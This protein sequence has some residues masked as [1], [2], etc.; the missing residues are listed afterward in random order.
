MHLWDA[1][2]QSAAVHGRWPQGRSVGTSCGKWDCGCELRL[3]SAALLDTKAWKG[4]P[5]GELSHA[6]C[7]CESCRDDKSGD[8]IMCSHHLGKCSRSEHISGCWRCTSRLFGWWA[9][10]HVCVG[11]CPV[12]SEPGHTVSLTLVKVERQ[13]LPL[14]SACLSLCTSESEHSFHVLATGRS[15]A[16][17]LFTSLAV[18]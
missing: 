9:S 5:P 2:G 15:S 11:L 18:C 8:G 6:L 3:D 7:I 1:M 12:R 16:E 14:V 17:C 10:P 4:W 13:N